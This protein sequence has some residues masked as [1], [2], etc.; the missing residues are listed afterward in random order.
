MIVQSISLEGFRN[1]QHMSAGFDPGIN[2][3][4]GENA[5]GK[6]N[7]VEAI[8]Y[9]SA[10][11]S[12]RARTDSEL[13][14]FQNDTARLMLNVESRSREFKLEADLRRGARR[15]LRSNGVKLKSASELSGILNT[16][17]FCPEDLSLIKEGAAMRR[18]FLDDAMGQLRPRY[19]AA[20]TEYRRLQ[21]QK[22]R[23]LRDY[24]D[25]PGMVSTLETYSLRMCQLGAT[26]I[27]FRAYY[28]EKL[29]AFAPAI[30]REFSG[31]REAL[32]LDYR[33]VKTVTDPLAPTQTLYT[34]LL[35]H[36]QSHKRAEWESRSCLSGPHKD[37]LEV[38][39]NG[40]SARTYSSQ[41]QTRTAALSLK[42]SEREIS[43]DDRGE[44]PVL[45]LDDVLSELDPGGRSS[46]STASVRGRCL[47]PAV[48]RKSRAV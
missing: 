37:D 30:H 3:I 26:I 10:C 1:Y 23:I 16:V 33:T 24:Q 12:H 14:R 20:V 45:L 38:R 25:D 36:M 32:E 4:V 28:I 27:H 22:T 47:S 21:E 15:S 29:K 34:Q 40:V 35:E 7:L 46:C 39:I 8:R 2:V 31:G 18:R 13:I 48:R 6:T 9:F 11:R 19:A 17:L 5:Q 43:R 41:G 42:L 44:Y